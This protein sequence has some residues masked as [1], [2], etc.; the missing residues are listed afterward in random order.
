MSQRSCGGAAHLMLPGFDYLAVA[1]AACSRQR[2]HHRRH[3]RRSHQELDLHTALDLPCGCG[4]G[5]VAVE[6]SSALGLLHYCRRYRRRGCQ[7]VK[8]RLGVHGG[9][10]VCVLGIVPA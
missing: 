2:R 7:N 10:L 4:L 9:R 5:T 3:R 6:I 8:L 1:G